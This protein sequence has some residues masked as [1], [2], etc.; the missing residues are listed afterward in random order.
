MFEQFK[1]LENPVLGR[2]YSPSRW[3]GIA[4]YK[5]ITRLRMTA[6]GGMGGACWY[7][8]VERLTEIPSNQIIDVKRYDGKQI[9]INTSYV[10]CAENFKLATAILDISEWARIRKEMV[11]SKTYY[12]LIDDNKSLILI[13]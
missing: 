10:V 2:E 11:N 4:K 8:Y 13:N 12:V 5:H 1:Y 9:C 3:T 7:E 6:G